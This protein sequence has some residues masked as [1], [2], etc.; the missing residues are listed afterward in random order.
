M[1]ALRRK[2]RRHPIEETGGQ[3]RGMMSWIG[4][5]AKPAENGKAKDANTSHA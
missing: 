1:E 5:S 4:A 3:L 2:E